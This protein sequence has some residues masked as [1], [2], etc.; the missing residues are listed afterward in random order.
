M[1]RCAKKYG[2]VFDTLNP[3]RAIQGQLP[4][5]HHLGMA[6][7]KNQ[8]NNTDP[9]VCLRKNHQIR[10]TEDAMSILVR[11]ADEYH[12]RSDA[13]TCAACSQDRRGLGCENPRKCIAAV[14]SKLSSLLP[15]WDP[16]RTEN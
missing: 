8:M 14:E 10:S 15:K 11:Q 16:K 5:W 3:S 7:G 4:F 12:N 2:V 13:C 9:C 1:L 6:P